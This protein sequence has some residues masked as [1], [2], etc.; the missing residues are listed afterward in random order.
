MKGFECK[1]CGSER[2]E[3]V[4]PDTTLFSEVDSVEIIDDEVVVSYMP[5]DH[6]NTEGGDAEQVYYQCVECGLEVPAEELQKIA[7][8]NKND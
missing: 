2:L 7:E 4:L 5:H 3:E 1:G 6:T 8:E